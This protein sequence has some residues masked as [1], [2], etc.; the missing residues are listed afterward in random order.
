MPATT[1]TPSL[2]TSGERIQERMDELGLSIK[3]V[4]DKAES[5]YE[6]IR[7]ITRGT[8]FPSKYF[9]RVLAEILDMKK[10]ELEELVTIDQIMHKH[11]KTINRIV[12]KN[13]ELEPIEKVWVKLT[14][15]QK[16]DFISQMTAVARRNRK[17]AIA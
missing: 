3:D 11:G 14:K 10:E 13:P 17:A 2:S 8:S 16:A 9:I 15:D 5:T 6:H 1:M 4:A 7:K 12:G